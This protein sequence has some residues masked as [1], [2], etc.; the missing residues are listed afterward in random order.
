MM[1]SE[2][3]VTS[4]VWICHYHPSS[5][6]GCAGVDFPQ[7]DPAGG[8]ISSLLPLAQL[9]VTDL[10]KKKQRTTFKP[11]LALI[12]FIISPQSYDESQIN[13]MALLFQCHRLL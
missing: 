13:H 2:M 6:M 11:V 5:P 4:N 7:S 3:E 10:S 9:P 12:V 1:S 8:F